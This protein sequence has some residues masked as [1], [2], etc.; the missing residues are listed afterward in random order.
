MSD[1]SP[2]Y[3]HHRDRAREAIAHMRAAEDEQRQA[4]DDRDNEIRAMLQIP[5]ASL[6]SVA[7]D[8]GVSKSLVAY[9]HREARAIRRHLEESDQ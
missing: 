1:T 2:T 6:G 8:L 5:G 7:A 9:I 4:R 3:A